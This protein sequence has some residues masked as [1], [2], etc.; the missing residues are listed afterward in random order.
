MPATALAVSQASLAI[1]AAGTAFSIMAANQQAAFAKQ[2]ANIQ[3]ANAQRQAQ[4][5]REAQVTKHMGDVKAQQAQT[6]AATKQIH[7]NALAAN[8]AWNAEQLK[9]DEA[10]SKAA[11]KAQEIYAKSIGAKGTVLASG[12]T[13]QS[14][15]L[16]AM[17]AERQA[18]LAQ[19]EENASL[20]SA[21]DAS[22][23]QAQSIGLQNQSADNQVLSSLSGPV[24]A[25]Q[26][27]PMPVGGNPLDLA[28]PE[29]QWT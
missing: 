25:P 9:V 7:N 10:R 4:F 2:Q 17:D 16:L 13:G 22:E 21:L 5:D 14:V 20:R 8:T 11:F 19:A 6:V 12:Q 23:V 15:G 29:Y 24:A 27:A 1:S 18:G 26:F 28:I 3:H